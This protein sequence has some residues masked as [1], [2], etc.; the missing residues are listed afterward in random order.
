[1]NLDSF[2]F[3]KNQDSDPDRNKAILYTIGLQ[4]TGIKY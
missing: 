3:N 1:M 2:Q 4:K